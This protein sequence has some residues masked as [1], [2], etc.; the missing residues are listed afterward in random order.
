MSHTSPR[1]AEKRREHEVTETE[2]ES[3]TTWPERNA[4]GDQSS[5]KEPRPTARELGA[6]RATQKDSH[7]DTNTTPSKIRAQQLY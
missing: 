4:E 7:L 1:K 2:S 6:A 5:E 3:D